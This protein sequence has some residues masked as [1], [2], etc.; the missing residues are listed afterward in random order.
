MK[1]SIFLFIISAIL[2]IACGNDSPSTVPPA[3]AATDSSS[4][5]PVADFIRDDIKQVD[6]FAGG[7]LRKLTGD[8][9]KDSGFIK[10][11]RFHEL[12]TNFMP[13][14]LSD[15]NAFNRDYDETSL[16][17]ETTGQVNFIY[18]AKI[19]DQQL[20]TIMVYI[21]PSL[22]TDNVQRI[23]MEKEFMQHDTLVEQKLNW[24]FREY[25]YIVTVYKP[26]NGPVTSTR[27][28]VIWDPQQF[29]E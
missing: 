23:Y 9:K 8:V 11:P 20:R 19:P 24:K 3:P 29:N 26:Q 16:M 13:P 15:S 2:F 18:N 10:L 6:S 27:E 7:I 1:Y 4:H 17:D 14:V 22:T 12:A 5:L 21:Q 28:K 25:F